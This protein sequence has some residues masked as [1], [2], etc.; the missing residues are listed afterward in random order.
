M[1]AE[2]S[3]NNTQLAMTRSRGGK[4]DM[5]K[6]FQPEHRYLP[7][8]LDRAHNGIIMPTRPYGSNSATTSGGEAS[9]QW[10]WYINMTPPTPEMYQC[11]SLSQSPKKQQIISDGLPSIKSEG[12]INAHSAAPL[13][14]FGQPNKVFEDLQKRNREKQIGWS[15]GVPL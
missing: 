12:I 14:E 11:R 7:K 6:E 2:Q 13:A 5:L 10:G 4:A 9:P 3:T 1:G 8:G 15:T